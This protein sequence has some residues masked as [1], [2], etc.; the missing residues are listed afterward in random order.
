MELIYRHLTVSKSDANAPE[1]TTHTLTFKEELP[2]ASP[3]DITMGIVG[4]QLVLKLSE[5]HAQAF[6][7]GKSYNVALALAAAKAAA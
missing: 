2:T 5:A 1:D 7:L 6:E 3:Q 4:S